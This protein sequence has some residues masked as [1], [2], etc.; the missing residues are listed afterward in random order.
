MAAT[1]TVICTV[2]QFLIVNSFGFTVGGQALIFQNRD[3]KD[4][5]TRP[6]MSVFFASSSHVQIVLPTTKQVVESL[7]GY[8]F[9]SYSLRFSLA[10]YRNVSIVKCGYIALTFV[11]LKSFLRLKSKSHVFNSSS[12]ILK[13]GIACITLFIFSVHIDSLKWPWT[14]IRSDLCF[15]FWNDIICTVYSHRHV[16]PPVIE[17]PYVFEPTWRWAG[18][19]GP[20]F[21]HDWWCFLWH[22]QRGI[23]KT[24][25]YFCITLLEP[26][27]S[28]TIVSST[29]AHTHWDTS[30]HIRP[31]THTRSHTESFREMGLIYYCWNIVSHT[32]KMNDG[33]I[34]TLIH[35][36]KMT[37]IFC[38]KAWITPTSE[39][40][41][42]APLDF[43][44]LLSK[45]SSWPPVLVTIRVST[46]YF[47]RLHCFGLKFS[48]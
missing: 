21:F 29:L 33:H 5:Q 7:F 22:W 17:D 27:A 14:I 3:V 26:D 34:C 6:R 35:S 2:H 24:T 23:S 19:G 8:K 13:K 40:P 45:I 30:K 25:N 46:A 12:S 10:Y 20:P 31:P 36:Y 43:A 39:L 42:W 9:Q 41:S 47:H 48:L 28:H 1:I 18:E 15:F 37:I 38:S 44:C 32:L 4:E 11:M 16:T